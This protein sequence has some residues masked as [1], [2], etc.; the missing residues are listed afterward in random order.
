MRAEPYVLAGRYRLAQRLGEGGAGTVWRAAD[1]M[2]DRQVAVKQ[3]RVPDGLTPRER[4]EFTG[5]AIHEARSAGRRSGKTPAPERWR[6]PPRSGTA[7]VPG[8]GRYSVTGPVSTRPVS[9][10]QPVPFEP[11]RAQMKK[12]AKRII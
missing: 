6:H 2:L 4:E 1:T 3:V 10:G 11:A 9:G 5:R 7:I 12:P 8:P